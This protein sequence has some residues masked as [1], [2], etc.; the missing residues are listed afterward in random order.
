MLMFE[1]ITEK[2]GTTS[3]ANTTWEEKDNT[4]L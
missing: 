2:N 4:N 3:L 1:D